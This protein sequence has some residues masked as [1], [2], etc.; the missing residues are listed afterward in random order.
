MAEHHLTKGSFDAGLL[1]VTATRYCVG[2]YQ[3]L[4]EMFGIGL[5]INQQRPVNIATR[6]YFTATNRAVSDDAY[7]RRVEWL[8]LYCCCKLCTF[9]M[10]LGAR[11]RKTCPIDRRS[12]FPI[13]QLRLRLSSQPSWHVKRP[14]RA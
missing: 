11:I 4:I 8:L 2:D 10:R 12:A 5:A 1:K 6:C 9:F 14:A 3:P 7:I 13:S